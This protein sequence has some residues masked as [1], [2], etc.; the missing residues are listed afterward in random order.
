LKTNLSAGE[1][2]KLYFPQLDSIRGISFITIFLFHTLSINYTNFLLGD[3]VKYLFNSLPLAI[4]VFFILSSFLLTYLALNEYKKRGNFSFRNYF[5]RRVLRIW[6]LYYFILILAFL[7]FPSIAHLFHFKISLPPPL[8]YIF[9]IANFYTI[10]HVFFLQFLWTISVEEQF[11]LF[12][13]IS[14]RYFHNNL[15]KI[16][17]SLFLI[18]LIFTLYAVFSGLK[19]YFNT[20]TYLFDFGSGGLAALLIFRNSFIIKRFSN[21]S[22]T[23]TLIFYVYLPIH[24]IL[25]YFL[26]KNSEGIT[27]NLVELLS[28]YLFIIYIA[29]FII[30]QMINISRV[31]IFEKNTFLIFTGK[32]SYG[33]YC[34]HGITITIINLLVQSLNINIKNWLM[35][36]IYFSINY[37]IATTSYFYLELPFLKLKAKWRRI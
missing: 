10:N 28:R 9:Y 8:F 26:N 29:F 32:I 2:S 37:F 13:G 5:T 11:Y 3:F 23:G 30:E 6:P 12:W 7:A 4:D 17:F 34:F 24:F 22:K 18:S 33:L 36:L 16:I 27:N 15:N 20:L 21:L 31:R 14:L 1:K 19:Y 35:V 25:F